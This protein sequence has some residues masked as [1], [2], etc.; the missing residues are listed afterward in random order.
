MPRSTLFPRPALFLMPAVL[1]GATGLAMAAGQP[2]AAPTAPSPGMSAPVPPA[3]RIAAV[4]PPASAPSAQRWVA[5]DVGHVPGGGSRSASGAP[6]HNFN[7][8]FASALEGRLREQGIAVRRLPTS[9]S[10][11]DRAQ[12]ARGAVLVVS[13]HHD[14]ARSAAAPPA[15]GAGARRAPTVSTGSGYKL[16]VGRAEPMACARTVATQLQTAGRHFSTSGAGA[17]ADKA[18]GVHAGREDALLQ[19]AIVPVLQLS[20]ADI[21]NPAEERLAAND[22]WVAQQASAVAKGLAGCLLRPA[23]PPAPAK[24]VDPT[25]ARAPATLPVVA[26]AAGASAPRRS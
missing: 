19:Q 11:A 23:S 22:G 24:R 1:G 15:A 20:L 16:R 6:E 8:R 3:A 14:A 4:V 21:A 25:A 2:T 12:R 18:F 17:W 10:L 9:L 7:L 26:P 13:V 5:L